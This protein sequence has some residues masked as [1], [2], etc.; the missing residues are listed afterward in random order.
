MKS[1]MRHNDDLAAIYRLANIRSHLVQLADG[2]LFKLVD[3]FKR[4]VIQLR[5]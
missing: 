3:N 1:R 4:S 5:F 2:D